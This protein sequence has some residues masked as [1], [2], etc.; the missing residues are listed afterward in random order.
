M[1]IIHA[2]M[3]VQCTEVSDS[4]RQCWSWTSSVAVTDNHHHHHHHCTRVGVTRFLGL[5]EPALLFAEEAAGGTGAGEGTGEADDEEAEEVVLDDDDDDD[6]DDV[7]AIFATST[8]TTSPFAAG[9]IDW[10]TTVEEAPGTAAPGANGL[11]ALAGTRANILNIPF[12]LG[13][14]LALFVP[15]LADAGAVADAEAGLLALAFKAAL[16]L[17]ARTGTFSSASAEGE[18]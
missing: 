16:V 8:T 13:G 9:L 6:D 4:I 15:L 2:L 5:A 12:G 17:A 14:L 3:H 7:E 18:R 1:Q 11:N 10:F